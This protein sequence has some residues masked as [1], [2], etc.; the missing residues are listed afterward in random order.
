MIVKD[1]INAINSKEIKPNE[2]E[3]LINK[4]I[5]DYINIYDYF[6]LND[7]SYFKRSKA[8]GTLRPLSLPP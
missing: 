7:L 5:F 8:G 3:K 1:I 2:S 4:H 6:E